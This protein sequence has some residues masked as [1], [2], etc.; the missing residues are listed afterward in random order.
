[1][2]RKL[3]KLKNE[4]FEYLSLDTIKVLYEDLG[5]EDS[6][7]YTHDLYIAI[8]TKYKNNE[9][10]Q[11]KCLIHEIRHYYQLVVVV[12]G[13][14]AEPQYNYWKEEFNMK[15]KPKDEMCKY[16]EIDAF[17]FTKYILKDWYGIDYH[18]HDKNYDYLLSKFINKY[19]I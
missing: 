7:F 4:L 1:M 13:I 16:I 11:M 10:E 9:L 18:H 3:I 19:Y 6:R 15:L 17:A 14:D 8:N 12:L 2:T 5:E